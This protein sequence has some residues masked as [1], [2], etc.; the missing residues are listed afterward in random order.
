MK[1]EK[2]GFNIEGS[3]ES[4]KN[5][6]API[7][8]KKVVYPKKGKHIDIE[9]IVEEKEVLTFN[10]AKRGVRNFFLFLLLFI[11][12]GAVYFLGVFIVNSFSTELFNN[13]NDI[14]DNSP[15]ALIYL[16]ADEKL[17]EACNEYALNY[18]FDYI[19]IDVGKLSFSRKRQ[20]REELN[21]YNLTSTLVIVKNGQP[22]TYFS[23]LKT[24]DELLNFLQKNYLVP[25]FLDNPKEIL[26]QFKVSSTA[27]E[28]TI[29]FLATNYTDKTD[30]KARSSQTISEENGLIYQEIKGYALSQRQ[31][32]KLMTQIG[33]SEIQDDLILYVSE[34]K[35][36]STFEAKETSESEYFHLFSNRGIIDINS[37]SYLKKILKKDFLKI[38]DEKKTNVILIETTDCSYCERVKPILGKISSQNEITIYYLDATKIREDVSDKIKEL[39][40]KEGLTTTPFVLIVENGKYRDSIIGLADKD[41]YSSKFLEYGI[42]KEEV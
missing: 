38:V 4:C 8:N 23:K 19:N 29:I 1:C 15:L 33:F 39:G 2:C 10:Q 7:E 6:G 41:L 35:I 30:E 37:G 9:D 11:I 31:L 34:G 24:T 25:N 42:I 32:I 26:E 27:T 5:C 40:Y 12:I 14:M 18:D 21:I 20:L 13:Y 17:D 28:D 22:I 36:V 16:G 3:N